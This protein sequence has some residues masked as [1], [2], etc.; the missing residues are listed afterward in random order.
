M[1][2]RNQQPESLLTGALF[3]CSTRTGSYWFV[4]LIAMAIGISTIGASVAI[5]WVA[6]GI[7]RR[8]YASDL[9]VG[10]TAALFSGIAIFQV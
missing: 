9:L 7:A 6:H 2:M 1:D 3:R 10:L 5:D 4:V 8:V